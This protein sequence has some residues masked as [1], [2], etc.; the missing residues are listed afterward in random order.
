MT[1]SNAAWCGVG[2]WIDYNLDG[3]F[4]STENLYHLYSAAA[5]QTYNFNITVPTSA[6]DGTFR[7][8]V[9]AG[10]GTDCYGITSTNGYGGCGAYQYGNFD[11]FTVRVTHVS[12][13]GIN[14]AE[15]N[16]AISLTASPIPAE[17]FLQV[18]INGK[19]DLN[20]ILTLTD[21]T[22]KSVLTKQVKNQTENMDV[23]SLA[24]G[25]YFL[26]YKDDKQT[27]VIKIK[28]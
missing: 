1:V 17:N 14:E 7:M 2:V 13:A 8:R 22:G 16:N 20:S 27:K 10:W 19:R 28:K 5:T 11:D 18:N 4:D 26:S 12:G 9:I 6:P 21:I 25:I 24:E 23:S 3:M 15:G